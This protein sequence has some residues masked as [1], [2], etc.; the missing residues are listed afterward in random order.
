MCTLGPNLLRTGSLKQGDGLLNLRGG[1]DR[2]G[3]RRIIGGDRRGDLR[4]IGGDRRGNRLGI[5]GDCRGDRLCMGGDRPLPR[6]AL[7]LRVLKW[8]N[9]MRASM[10]TLVT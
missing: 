8:T 1:G 2:R 9:E 5:G 10:I 4:D 3:D 6:S 7:R